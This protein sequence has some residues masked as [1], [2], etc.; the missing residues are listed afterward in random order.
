MTAETSVQRTV[1][2]RN[3]VDFFS[4]PCFELLRQRIAAMGN[5]FTTDMRQ[6]IRAGE[7]DQA[8]NLNGAAEAIDKMFLM[9][10]DL[11]QGLRMQAKKRMKDPDAHP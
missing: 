10:R 9:L 4:N 6:A 1:S 3:I 11:E 2:G 7:M 5:Q 8:K